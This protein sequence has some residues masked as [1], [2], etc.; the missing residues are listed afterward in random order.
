MGFSSKGEELDYDI[1]GNVLYGYVNGGVGT[2]GYEVTDRLVFKFTLQPNGDYSFE[3]HDQIDHDPPNDIIDDL[4]GLGGSDE[5]FDLQD[6]IPLI[7][8]EALPLGLLIQATDYDGDSVTLGDQFSIRIRDDV[9][10]LKNVPGISHIVDEDDIDTI[11]APDALP[12][13]STGTSPED[14]NGD[15]SFTGGP[16]DDGDNPA[17]GEGPAF[18]SGSVAGQ[19]SV[20]AD[21]DITFSF[22]NPLGDAVQEGVLA[23]LGLKSQGANIKY[24]FQGNVLFGYVGA[25]DYDPT[26]RLVF[27]FTIQPNGDYSFELHDQVDHDPPNDVED[28]ISFPGSDENFDLVDGIPFVDITTLDFGSLIKATDYDGDS[29]GLNGRLNIQ[30]R[31]DIPVTTGQTASIRVEEDELSTVLVA[32]TVDLTT[33][34]PDGDLF[35]DE[36]T[37]TAAQLAALVNVG[38]DEPVNFDLKAIPV[39][40][41]N[42][43]VQTTGNV[44]VTSEGVNL[45]YANGPVAGTIIG[46]ADANGNGQ[47]AGRRTRSFPSHRQR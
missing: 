36:A 4:P 29:V 40:G 15:G 44:T 41:A 22:N 25:G 24:D 28:V 32:P 23:A 2:D 35:T 1:Q 13:G 11:L 17:Q 33:G 12:G 21:E 30:I 39:F 47:Q 10:V 16:S 20:G 43:F 42:P 31:D 5:N 8:F 46:Y 19:V 37:F 27:K 6:N 7:D 14:G 26:D 18:V 45:R 38:A 34:I 9:P 3:L